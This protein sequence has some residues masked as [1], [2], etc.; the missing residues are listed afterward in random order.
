M[1]IIK[2]AAQ[3]RTHPVAGAIAGQLR[4]CQYAYVQ[5][6]GAGAVNQAIK[7][8]IIARGFLQAEGLDLVCIPTLI[9]TEIEGREY[10]VVRIVVEVCGGNAGS[11]D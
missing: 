11:G 10:T 2:V 7:A 6:I 3:S 4:Q 8:I 1:D 5:A 9:R